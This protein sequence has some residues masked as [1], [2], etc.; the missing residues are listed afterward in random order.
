MKANRTT[1]TSIYIAANS[2]KPCVAA[3]G[4]YTL[5]VGSALA[6]EHFGMIRDD[7]GENIS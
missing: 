1:G 5:Q 3:P 4:Y 2:N 7:D 6:R